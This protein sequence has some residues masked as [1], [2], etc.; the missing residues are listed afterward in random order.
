MGAGP[1]T[2]ALDFKVGSSWDGTECTY[3]GGDKKLLTSAQKT[4]R[5]VNDRTDILL[6][7]SYGWNIH[8]KFQ[9]K[10]RWRLYYS[11][12]G[13]SKDGEYVASRMENRPELIITGTF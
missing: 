9:I 3:V 13:N 8:P 12:W 7:L 10:P 11:S 1:G 5:K 4:G 6:D 2:L